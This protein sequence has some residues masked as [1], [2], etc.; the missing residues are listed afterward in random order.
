MLMLPTGLAAQR[1][2]VFAYNDQIDTT[3]NTVQGLPCWENGCPAAYFHQWFVTDTTPTF[4]VANLDTI[5]VVNL[6]V[7]SPQGVVEFD[8]SC[9]CLDWGHGCEK[10]TYHRWVQAGSRVIVGTALPTPLM[11]GIYPMADSLPADSLADVATL[12]G[13]LD[14]RVVQDVPIREEKPRRLIEVWTGRVVDK[15]SPN[16]V[17]REKTLR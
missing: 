8:T 17:Y 10:F 2:S 15:P 3:S 12:C 13:P 6:Q 1:D 16:S 4:W 5:G 7:V 14:E 9:M 11:I